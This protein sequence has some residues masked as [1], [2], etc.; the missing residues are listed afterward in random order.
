MSYQQV[1]RIC[2]NRFRAV[3]IL[4]TGLHNSSETLFETT[5]FSRWFPVFSR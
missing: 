3:E 4:H 5:F 1:F 2:E